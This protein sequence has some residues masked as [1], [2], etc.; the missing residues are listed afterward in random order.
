[1]TQNDYNAITDK[2]IR[3]RR[4][5]TSGTQNY[6]LTNQNQ[7]QVQPDALTKQLS[8]FQKGK[9]RVNTSITGATNC[10]V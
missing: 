7:I 2:C 10:N 4:G 5:G 6:L 1:M 3:I 8:N 9:Y